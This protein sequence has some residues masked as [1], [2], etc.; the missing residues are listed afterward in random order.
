ML[1]LMTAFGFGVLAAILMILPVLVMVFS[2]LLL[3][4][5]LRCST[6]SWYLGIVFHGTLGLVASGYAVSGLVAGWST[7]EGPLFSL[8]GMIAVVE[9]LVVGLMLH[10]DVRDWAYVV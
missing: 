5:L 3:R 7:F 2:V 8:A 1:L 6:R 9:F 10:Q 4:A